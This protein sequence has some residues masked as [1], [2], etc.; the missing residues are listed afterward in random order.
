MASPL[1][2]NTATLDFFDYDNSDVCTKYQEA[3]KIVN[4][5][6][7]GL[8]NQIKPGAQVLELCEF[9]HTVINAA[10]SKLFTK[11]VNGVAIERGVA[12]PVCISINDCI[13]NYSPLPEEQR[14]SLCV[15]DRTMKVLVLLLLLC[16]KRV[17]FA[18]RFSVLA[19]LCFWHDAANHRNNK[20]QTQ[21][22]TL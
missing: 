2:L 14:V 3:A 11:K 9:G 8:L 17:Q 4:L 22:I 1:R 20:A 10:A 5:A 12:F 21:H 15:S 16:Q 13:C 19:A 7:E 18:A 6:L